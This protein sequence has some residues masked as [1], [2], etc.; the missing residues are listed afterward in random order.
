MPTEAAAMPKFKFG[1]RSGLGIASLS[2]LARA[3]SLSARTRLLSRVSS[4]RIMGGHSIAPSTESPVKMKGKSMFG[5]QE[6]SS[7]RSSPAHGFGSGTRFGN[8][9]V[10]LGPE[11]AKT[12]S[13][14]TTPGPHYETT[15][16]VGY[17]ADSG[18]LSQASWRF[19][20]QERFGE[21]RSARRSMSPGPGAYDN[22][23]AM[24]KQGLSH[25]SSFPL[26]GFGTV[27][28]AMASKVCRLSALINCPLSLA[29]P[30]FLSRLSPHIA[31]PSSS[32]TTA[33]CLP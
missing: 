2:Q 3:R 23:S 24:G 14:S 1:S 25:R 21:M 6:L 22:A 28:R 15:S 30:F 5:V 20:T 31:S 7:R 32:S 17:Q 11:H 27:D 16:A 29:P 33:Q 8:N 9:K 10:Y 4:E 19:G 12:S 18:K 13:I 26:Y